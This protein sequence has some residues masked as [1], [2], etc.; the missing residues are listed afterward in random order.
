V[1]T[2]LTNSA[3]PKADAILGQSEQ[4]YRQQYMGIPTP[5]YSWR[6]VGDEFVLEDF[7]DAAEAYTGG[8]VREWSGLCASVVY[9]DYPHVLLDL[10]TCATEQRTVRRETPYRQPGAEQERTLAL[11]YVFIPVGMV[12]L[13]TEDVT[14]HKQAESQRETLAAEALRQQAGMFDLAPVA[15]IALDL[16]RRVTYWNRGAEALYGWS[17]D[18]ASGQITHDLLLTCF[19]GSQDVVVRTLLELGAWEGELQQRRRDGMR[20]IVSSRQ[21]VQRDATGRPTAIL[22]I[23]T[24][25]TERS[26]TAAALQDSETRL[27]AILD[28]TP[29]IMFLKDL[30]GRYLS[31]NLAF[32][33]VL[34]PTPLEA[35]GKTDMEL[36]AEP[37]AIA[38]RRNDAEVVQSRRPIQ[39]EVAHDDDGARTS[40]VMKYPLLDARGEPYAVGAMATDITEWKNL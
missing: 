19:P 39:F 12:M 28:N 37:I 33:R 2:S 38:L 21:A 9:A 7:N 20:L 10:M 32:E 11:T 25:I 17:A 13:Q 34:G 3:D 16:D 15:I 26:R 35:R 24:D 29:S 1:E 14:E 18:E 27:R 36:F 23:N 30:D 8:R 22:E 40:L 6:R 4:R 5:T 31:T